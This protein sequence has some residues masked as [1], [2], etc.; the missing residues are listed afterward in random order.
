VSATPTITSATTTQTITEA[1][2]S[3]LG[4]PI[5][6]NASK[7]RRRWRQVEEDQGK[8]APNPERDGK[9]KQHQILLVCGHGPKPKASSDNQSIMRKMCKIHCVGNSSRVSATPK[10]TS[11]T[12]TQ[13]IT[14]AA[15]SNLGDP[16]FLNA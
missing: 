12:T 3:N 1:A 4:D 7:E 13:T 15:S 16:I 8:S 14:E 6:L 5:F 2:S 11:A 9:Y 10:I